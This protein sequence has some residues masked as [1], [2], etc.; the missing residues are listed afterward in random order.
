MAKVEEKIKKPKIKKASLT[1]A[2]ITF[3]VSIVI[4]GFIFF[5]PMN[6]F[7][8]DSNSYLSS[9]FL[10]QALLDSQLA[11]DKFFVMWGNVKSLS[12]VE[13]LYLWIMVCPIVSSLIAIFA[14]KIRFIQ[15]INLLFFVASGLALVL[16]T[17]PLVDSVLSSTTYSYYFLYGRFVPFVGALLALL[18]AELVR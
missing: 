17:Q 5:V 12:I 6:T 8:L 4:F 7:K 10:G 18:N 16:Y 9:Q 1:V 2:I 14:R 15:I 11:P 3:L 13:H